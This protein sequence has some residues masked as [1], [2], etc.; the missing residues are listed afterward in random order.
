MKV[1]FQLSLFSWLYLEQLK[2]SFKQA[3]HQGIHL[4]TS[5]GLV[6]KENQDRAIVARFRSVNKDRT[7]TLAALADGMG[8]M[9]EGSKCASLALS[10]LLT[11]LIESKET[12]PL[13]MLAVAA[14]EA[15]IAV[16]N[17]YGGKGGS[18]L[19][20]VLFDNSGNP[21]AINIGDSRI[22]QLDVGDI[23]KQVSIDDTIDGQLA[24]MNK[25][26]SKRPESSQLVQYVGM[27]EGME[28][29]EV[30]LAN[31]MKIKHLLL[32]TDGAHCVG[33]RMI[34]DIMIHSQN[35]TYFT[36]RL[37]ALSQWIGGK[38]NATLVFI[39]YKSA[40]NFMI[41]DEIS[42]CLIQICNTN[43]MFSSP[44]YLESKIIDKMTNNYDTPNQAVQKKQRQDDRISN[45]S[46][47]GKADS[48][49]ASEKVTKT[50]F[51]SPSSA[52]EIIQK[53]KRKKNK[54]ESKDKEEESGKIQ[55]RLFPKPKEENK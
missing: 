54:K 47:N 5:L 40:K 6:R 9:V 53:S 3:F 32:S 43:G 52:R 42:E 8:G 17:R 27:G 29:Q 33:D 38:D 18:T 7:Y 39:D 30:K 19:S 49:E 45:E 21:Y 23:F 34:E 28:P 11:K 1:N 12:N 2:D 15:N 25:E 36:N 48:N 31:K 26:P 20:A 55:I 4:G 24:A 37:L 50:E 16:Y 22:Y 44:Y 13:S 51:Q 41:N 10:T 14:R 46:E 35:P